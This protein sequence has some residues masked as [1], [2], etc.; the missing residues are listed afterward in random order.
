MKNLTTQKN[1]FYRVLFGF[2]P[3]FLLFFS[4]LTAFSNQ[5]D[6]ASRVKKATQKLDKAHQ[7]DATIPVPKNIVRAT[8]EYQGGAFF[9][10]ARKSEIK[11][12]KCSSCHNNKQV[13]ILNAADI[14]HADIKVNHGDKEAPLACNTCHSSDDRD[15]LVTS[16][17]SKIDLD[18]VYDMCGQCHFRQKKDW[19]GGAH[20]KR[21][22]YWAGER[23][24]K[25][26][27]S[28][29]NPHY[30][31]FEKRWPKTYSVPLK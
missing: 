18:H 8:M 28:C 31:R 26:C 27:T 29:H 19:I 24:V 4:C 5:Q 3:G 10:E 30:P 21:V 11:R 6:V 22:T 16:K 15:F 25:N 14:S 1:L 20:G 12:F 2:I 13:S 7:V 17:T 9:T 23:V